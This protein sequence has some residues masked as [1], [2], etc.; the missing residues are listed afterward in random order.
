MTQNLKPEEKEKFKIENETRA[1]SRIKLGLL[2]NE[3]GEKNNLNVSEIEIQNEINKQL[4]TMP[5]QEKLVLDYYKKNP[6]AT[7]SIKGTLYEE[8]ILNLIKSKMQITKKKLSVEEADKLIS[9]NNQNYSK[10]QNVSKQ[11]DKEKS[12]VKSKKIS[13]K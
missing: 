11:K 10:T 12:A 5:G 7:Q 8:K 4:K 13:K 3:Y 9:G 1:K 6:M 2:L